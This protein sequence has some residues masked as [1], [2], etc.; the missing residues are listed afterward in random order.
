MQFRTEVEI[1]QPGWGIEH[2]DKLLLLGSCFADNIGE[3]LLRAGFD[4]TVNP[5]GTLYNP[6]SVAHALERLLDA[7]PFV[8][9]DLQDFGIEGWGVWDAHSLLCRPKKEDALSALNARFEEASGQLQ[10]ASVLM[11]TFGTAWVYKLKD[12]GAV[13]ANCHH[14]PASRFVREK[15]SVEEILELWTPLL[16]RLHK[17][18][19]ALHILLTVSPIR[20]MKDGAHGNQLS[21]ATL[22][23]AVDSLREADSSA[24]TKPYYF[25]A[26]ELVLD[27]LRDYRFYADD[28]VHPS[29]AA[30]AF[31]WE[32]FGNTFFNAR[33]RE[34]AAKAEKQAKARDHRPL[35]NTTNNIILTLKS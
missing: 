5:F 21:K 34:E 23:L 31:L 14:E 1:E 9:A 25:P 28:M 16:K 22:M 30:V 27:E 24:Q 4:A 13:V 20:H 26:Y 6:A 19:P 17:I 3:K 15:M 12:T 35:H 11:L 18:N 32:K 2:S 7:R 29:Q 10:K 8:E 33:T